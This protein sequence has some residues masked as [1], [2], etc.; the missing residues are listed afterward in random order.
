MSYITIPK[1][2]FK[3]PQY[4]SLSAEAKLL[5]G[6][7]VDRSSL[8]KKNGDAW[9]N[10]YGEY[11]VYFTQEE[12]MKKL[13]CGHD[14]ATKIVRELE[15]V[16]LIKRIPQGLGKPHMLI[17]N[18]VLQDADNKRYRMRNDSDLDGDDLAAI[19]TENNKRNINYTDI[20]H[21]KSAVEELLKENISF[22]IL[23]KELN[24]DFLESVVA[25]ATDAVC[26]HGENIKIAGEQRSR[27]E[28]FSRF[29]RL[30]DIHIRYIADCLNHEKYPICS[31]RGYLLKHL[32]EA[33]ESMEIYY[34]ARVAY[35]ET[36]RRTHYE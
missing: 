34:Q 27:K 35:D 20:C 13:G 2:F 24:K 30:T 1:V 31:V 4:Q 16:E 10:K 18:K 8:S 17:V 11:F 21:S 28:V 32:F 36:K 23:I 33:E 7:L 22:N 14:K 5:Y 19:N 3:D 9:R 26:G 29:I 6:F 12:V 25:V 15:K